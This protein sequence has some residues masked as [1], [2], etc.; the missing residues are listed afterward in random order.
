MTYLWLA[1]G[2]IVGALCRYHGARF[3]AAR[4]AGDFPLGT[5]LINIGG[6]LLLGFLIGVFGNHPAWPVAALTALCAT[7][8][9]G[10]FTTFSSFAFESTQLWRG[11]QRR[12]ALLN[13]LGQPL[14]GGLAA[15]AGLF[16]GGRL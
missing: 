15:W 8:F 13:L 16:F 11:G 3:V 5:L 10:A 12:Q 1:L 6:S 14:L 7:G 2:G 9:C 4:F